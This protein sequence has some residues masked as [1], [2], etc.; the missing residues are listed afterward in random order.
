MFEFRSDAA[1]AERQKTIQCLRRI[2]IGNT[3]DQLMDSANSIRSDILRRVV[4]DQSENH[5][6]QWL[7]KMH[8]YLAE[9]ARD[10]VY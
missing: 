9:C 7:G 2:G 6:V 3:F 4:E 10:R 8:A 1:V 5:V